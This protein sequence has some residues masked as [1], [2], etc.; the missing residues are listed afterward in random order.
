M[1]ILA[2][3][4]VRNEAAYL[5]EWLAHHRSAGVTDFLVFSNDCDDGT[6]LMLDRLDE[7]GLVTHVRNPGPHDKGGIQFTAMKLADKRPEVAAADWIITLDIDE[8]INVH[9][10]DH[11]VPALLAALPEA[12]AITLTWRIFGSSDIIRYEDRPVTEEF[13]RA[14]P[15]VMYWPWRASMF[16]T[17]F[18]NDGTYGKLGIHRPRNPGPDRLKGARWFDGAGR[19]LPPQFL[20][21]Q[22]FS[23]FGRPNYG[24][25]Q[26]NH[27]P[28]G[29]MENFVLKADRG[30]AVHGSDM[31][32]LDYWV[33][34][35]YNTD[36]DTSISALE[37]QRAAALAALKSD[38]RLGTLH[39]EAVAW[40]KARFDALMQ[41]EPYRALFGRL[42]QTP[43]SRPVRPEEARLLVQ[44][45]H[46]G[47]ARDP[48]GH[49]R[50]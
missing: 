42:L 36:L 41:Q 13:I 11:T 31:L 23:P 27:Y 43:P 21:R 26:L 25:V 39:D 34:R 14:A 38:T 9:V 3:L 6:D 4:T 30:R 17:L 29:S 47:K 10:G 44:H 15:E 32:D 12:S 16:K 5:L 40:R 33:E 1:R 24:L 18:R 45:A 35:N 22:I 46:R 7:Q 2:V 28:L 19:E 20:K 8:F 48:A 37:P 49:A 50:R